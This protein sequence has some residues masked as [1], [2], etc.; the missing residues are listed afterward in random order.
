MEKVKEKT[1]KPSKNRA[2]NLQLGV[3]LDMIG[4]RTSVRADKQTELEVT[5]VGVVM[6]SHKSKRKV[7]VPFANLRG[8]ELPYETDEE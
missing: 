3:G 8:V 6:T 4:S 5:G 7:L 1:V 2:L